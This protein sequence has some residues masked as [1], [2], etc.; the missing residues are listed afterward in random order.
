MIRIC[1]AFKTLASQ[2]LEQ[3]YQTDDDLTFQLLTYELK[4]WSKKN[5]I[6]LTAL[7][8][9]KKLLAHPCC[10]MLMVDL[11]LGGMRIR[12]N[13][14]LKV[15]CSILFPPLI[16]LLPF[17]TQEQLLYQPQTEEEFHGISS[18][19][20]FAYVFSLQKICL[21]NRPERNNEEESDDDFG[22]SA[23]CSDDDVDADVEVGDNTDRRK[24]SESEPHDRTKS[25]SK[26]GH[27]SSSSS[28]LSGKVVS[29]NK[30]E[31]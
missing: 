17:K 20:N 14:G 7:A 26:N 16:F 4:Y 19:E 27:L 22:S 25:F 23:E 13:A 28:R 3:C 29:V 30:S 10:Q 5:C 1:R 6:S 24:F 18:T 8:S 2:L 21:E 12:K 11:W 15:F 31:L 9:H